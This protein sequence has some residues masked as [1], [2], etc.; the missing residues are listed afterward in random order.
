VPSLHIVFRARNWNPRK[1]NEQVGDER[2]NSNETHRL[3]DD[4]DYQLR[5]PLSD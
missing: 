3:Y 1:S 4:G 5:K 2:F